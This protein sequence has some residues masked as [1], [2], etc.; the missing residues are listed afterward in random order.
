MANYSWSSTAAASS[1]P[2]FRSWAQG[3]S[4]ALA[5]IGMVR[6]EASTAASNWSNVIAGFSNAATGTEY[7]WEVWAFPSSATQTASPLFF[8]VGYQVS[9][10]TASTPQLTMKF[11]TAQGSGG[12]VTGIG[13][14]GA[15]VM[16]PGNGTTGQAAQCFASCDGHGFALVHSVDNTNNPTASRSWFVVDR[17]RNADG[18]PQTGGLAVFR[19]QHASNNIFNHNFD[20]VA[21]EYNTTTFA[22][23]PCVTPGSIQQYNSY[24]KT[25][26]EVQLFP[27]WSTTKNGHGVS[28]MISTYA[29]ND[30]VALN[31]QQVSWLPSTGSATT[32]TVKALGNWISTTAHDAYQSPGACL[33]IWWSDP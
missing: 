22:Y 20:L 10:V 16:T 7:A 15:L 27:W 12:V 13:G 21:N 11:A 28:K 6:V 25:N 19:G 5:A 4:T 14:T 17:Y 8:R 18:T 31:N 24:L 23:A 30:I 3:I 29:Q 26:G 2:V 32:R 1:E 9:T 33:A